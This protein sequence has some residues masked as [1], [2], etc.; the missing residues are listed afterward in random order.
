ML[1]DLVCEQSNF[2]M[3]DGDFVEWLE[4][5]NDSKGGAI[6]LDNTKPLRFV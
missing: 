4:A 2:G 6:F 1:A 3:L 5:M